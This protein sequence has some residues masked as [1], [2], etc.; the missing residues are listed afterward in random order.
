M[1]K[2]GQRVETLESYVLEFSTIA[3]MFSLD[4]SIVVYIM[5]N[6]E[7][8]INKMQPSKHIFSYLL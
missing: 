6:G 5:N 3:V 7:W 2:T 4:E 1:Y 8:Q